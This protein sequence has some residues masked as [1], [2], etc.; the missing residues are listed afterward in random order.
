MQQKMMCPKNDCITE[1]SSLHKGKNFCFSCGTKLIPMEPLTPLQ[2]KCGEKVN[3]F[4]Q[5]CPMCGEQLKKD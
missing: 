4:D 5:W 3:A 2:C 1:D